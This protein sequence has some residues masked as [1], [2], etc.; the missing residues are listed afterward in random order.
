M[1]LFFVSIAQCNSQF[2]LKLGI[3]IFVLQ[4][5]NFLKKFLLKIA[6]KNDDD[7]E[8]ERVEIHLVGVHKLLDPA[9]LTTIDEQPT[10]GQVIWAFPQRTT[11]RARYPILISSPF[12]GKTDAEIRDSDKTRINYI[13]PCRLC[14][15]PF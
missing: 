8:S 13:S 9:H 15:V 1:G 4:N 7:L 10:F 12:K 14:D 6:N 5:K 2:R 11:G 3:K